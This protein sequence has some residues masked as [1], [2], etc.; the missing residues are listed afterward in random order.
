MKKTK[1]TLLLS[2][3]AAH[4]SL[5]AGSEGYQV[6]FRI[7]GLKDTVC[8][9]ANYYGSGTYVTDT[10]GVDGQGRCIFTAPPDQPKGIYIF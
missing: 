9:I 7:H 10:I 6:R 1:I 4:M 5:L 3:L 8:L 2:V